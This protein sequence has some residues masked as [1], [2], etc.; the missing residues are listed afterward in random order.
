[1]K[2]SAQ[3]RLRIDRFADVGAEEAVIGALLVEPAVLEW[4]ELSDEC[5]YSP[6]FR[7]IWTTIAELHAEE[8]AIDELTVAARMRR[9][10]VLDAIN[11]EP[12]L[13][14]CA[15][16][17]PS[18][19]R[20][21]QYVKILHDRRVAR[22]LVLLGGRVQLDLERGEESSEVLGEALR[23]LG[24]IDTGG[25]ESAPPLDEVVYEVF[26]GLIGS[27]ERAEDLPCIPTGIKGLDELTTGIPVGVPTIVAARPGGGKS[28]FCLEIADNAAD[29]GSGVLV[30][31]Y[32]N[33]VW[34]WGERLLAR[35]A[36][37]DVSDVR[38]RQIR[39]DALTRAEQATKLL[40]ERKNL[41]VHDV[42]GWPIQRVIRQFRA[43]RRELGLEMLI[44]D[45]IQRCPPPYPGRWDKHEA[46]T[47][48]IHALG[49][50]AGTDNVAVVVASQIGRSVVQRDGTERAATYADLSGSKA[51]EE[52]GKLIL[53]LYEPPGSKAPRGFR[54]LPLGYGMQADDELGTPLDIL[55]LKNHQGL[56]EAVINAY[57]DKPH[58]RIQT[59]EN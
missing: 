17:M 1:M 14:K 58:C 32:E 42:H 24:E 13:S 16:A 12:T 40:R 45:F 22:E 18:G 53:A 3:D 31:N 43:R 5:F 9:N 51:L 35:R 28:T 36:L 29:G 25:R 26:R 37:V 49:D 20:V 4:V 39:G 19:G 48:N 38:A 27:G 6:V 34:G 11:G 23:R 15:L 52:T 2:T 44:V 55:V 57:F 30:A 33:P 7:H 46:I 59:K 47:E 10:G 54:D 21:E 8:V 41:V 56:G 50:F